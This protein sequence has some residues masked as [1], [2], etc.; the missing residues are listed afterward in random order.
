MTERVVAPHARH[1]DLGRQPLEQRVRARR[2]RPVVG[3]LQHVDGAQAIH[4][5]ALGLDL[6]VAREEQPSPPVA[7]LDDQ[8][9][10]V[11]SEPRV[12]RRT[13]P[14]HARLGRAEPMHGPAQLVRASHDGAA[15]S[16]PLKQR[17]KGPLR[18]LALALTRVPDLAHL[19]RVEERS[20]PAVVIRVRMADHQHVDPR[21]SSRAQ[22]RDDRLRA[23]IGTAACLGTRRAG[24]AV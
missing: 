20:H 3:H 15:R 6:H 14:E 19:H 2:A 24:S 16:R 17:G 18:V 1:R 23:R 12:V 7:Q 13:G 21:P 9:V 8:R 22:Q 4:Q 10:V 11:R 5:R